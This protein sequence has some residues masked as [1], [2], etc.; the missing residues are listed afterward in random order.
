MLKTE[1]KNIFNRI[2]AHYDNFTYDTFKLDEWHEILK[3]YDY[4]DVNE[5]IT[6]HVQNEAYGSNIPKLNYLIS[7]LYKSKEKG[8]IRQYIV[9]CPRCGRSINTEKLDKHTYRCN[10]VYYIADK[11]KKIY[12]KEVNMQ[13]L[14]EMEQEEFDTLYNHFIA[15]IIDK[16]PRIEAIGIMHQLYPNE[17]SE[18][19]HDMISELANEIIKE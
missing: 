17:T 15:K 1:T 11:A 18:N 19:I 9:S 2:K 6:S 8:T 13:K 14:Y 7:G 10:S 5:K 3:E 12:G 16:V 4:E